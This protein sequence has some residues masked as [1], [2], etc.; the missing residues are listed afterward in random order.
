MDAFIAATLQRYRVPGAAVAIIQD[1]KVVLSKGYGFRDLDAKKPIDEDTIFQLASVTKALT[2]TLAGVLVDEG[3]LEF[4]KPIYNYL[5]QFTHVDPYIG[6]NL[7]MRDL[8]AHRSGWPEF[9]GD[10]IGEFG[11]PAEDIVRRLSNFPPTHSFR[12]T[13][14]YSNIG[15]FLAGQVESAVAGGLPWETVLKQRV[16]DPLG[17][18]R[19][20]GTYTAGREENVSK[21]YAFLDG[22]LTSV[23]P[24]RFSTL[25]A[26]G[27]ATSSVKDMSKWL[28]MLLAEGQTPRGK[29]MKP[30]TVREL[31]K[32][33]MVSDPTLAEIAPISERTGFYYGLGFGSYDYANVQV[34]EKGGAIAGVRTAVV[35]VP[36]KKAAI[37]IL[38]NLNLTTFPEAIRA[39]W[40][41]RL[42]NHPGGD[43]QKQIFDYD[44]KL[45]QLFKAPF[46]PKNPK[47]WP[48]PMDAL[49]GTYENDFY[50]RIEILKSGNE[51]FAQAGPA[52]FRGT[53]K[54]IDSGMFWLRW[55]GVTMGPNETTFPIGEDGKATMMLVDGLGT[56]TRVKP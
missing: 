5:P 28:T 10:V 39:E 2:G 20:G 22:K 26:S 31:F 56:F 7:T 32:R 16:Y 8:L 21:S 35:L 12:E 13:A 48:F 45:Q 51:F 11:Y 50:G 19:S 14:A 52:K 17:M 38:C 18:T 15:F 53:L 4:D 42:L 47:P 3:K 1:G 41:S 37:V 40:L 9:T 29:F 33:S 36:E 55:P 49:L 46:L 43:D 34:I 24:L 30:E 27:A 54:H 44:S 6:R 25:R 23:D